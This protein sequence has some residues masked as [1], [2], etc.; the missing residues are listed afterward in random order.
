MVRPPGRIPVR[1]GLPHRGNPAR[2][3]HMHCITNVKRRSAVRARA[4]EPVRKHLAII[5]LVVRWNAGR[6]VNKRAHRAPHLV[7]IRVNR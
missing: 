6:D 4:L 7:R 2:I 1:Q 3:V 5:S